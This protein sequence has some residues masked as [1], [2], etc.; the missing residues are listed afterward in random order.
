MKKELFIGLFIGLF[1]CSVNAAALSFAG[2]FDNGDTRFY[3][4]FDVTSASTVNLTSFGYAGGTNAAGNVIADGGF[5]SQLF[6]FNSSGN[7]VASDDDA[8]SVVSASSGRSW[9]ALL[10]LVLGIDSYTA[11]LTQFKN[12]YVSGDLFTGTWSGAGVTGFM[13]VSGSQRTSAYAFDISGDSI[14][15]VT[16]SNTN[17]IPEPASI[18][19]LGF[20]LAGFVFSR[21]RKQKIA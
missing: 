5:D 14:T 11:V 17:A 21:R 15:N 18:A 4:T 8:S 9:D 12:N 7:L 16:A 20:G 10:S 6:L 13:D 3:T 1:A 19:L 2:N